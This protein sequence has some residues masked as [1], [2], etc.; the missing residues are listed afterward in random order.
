MKNN[1]IKS[2]ILSGC[3]AMTIVSCERKE[4]SAGGL[5]LSDG[6]KVQSSAKVFLPGEEVSNSQIKE[7]EWYDAVVP[8]TV[9][10]TLIRNGIYT[11]V[12]EG[13]NYENIDKSLFDTTWWYRKEF[14][15]MRDYASLVQH[16]GYSLVREWFI[17]QF[18]DFRKN[19]LFYLSNAPTV[20]P[21]TAVIAD[22]EAKMDMA[23]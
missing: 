8:S 13:T 22:M 4:L 23:G 7:K 2:L 17:K 16:N 19:P 15:F 21:G 3:L 9:M 5:L 6:W 20:L 11:D 12:L 10:G 14:E 18:P 1:L